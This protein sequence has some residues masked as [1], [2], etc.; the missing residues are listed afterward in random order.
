MDH[1]RGMTSEDVAQAAL[2]AIEKGKAETTLTFQGKLMV[3]VSRFLP[4]LADRIAAKRVRALFVDEIEARKKE[5]ATPAIPTRESS[6][7]APMA[8]E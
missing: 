1:M 7:N 8:N 2:A 5:R 3:F 4:R 6:T